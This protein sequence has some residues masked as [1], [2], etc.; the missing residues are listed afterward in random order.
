MWDSILSVLTMLVD[1]AKG[2][3]GLGT[4]GIISATVMLL[5]SLWKSS[6]LQPYWAKL[7]D[8]LKHWIGPIFGV[9]AALASMQSLSWSAILTGLSG[10]LLAAAVHDLLDTLKVMPWVSAPYV[11]IINIIESFLGAP[12]ASL[13][14]KG[15]LHSKAA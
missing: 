7:P 5:V 2:L 10:G 1:Y 9:L 11:Y 12:P 4:M 3:S 8:A 14:V 15:Q 6:A 13:S